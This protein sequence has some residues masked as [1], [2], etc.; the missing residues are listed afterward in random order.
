MGNVRS[1]F[2]LTVLVGA[3]CVL[4]GLVV[5]RPSAGQAGGPSLPV[6]AGVEVPAVHVVGPGETLWKVARRWGPGK[7]PRRVVHEIQVLNGL[8]GGTIHPGQRLRLPPR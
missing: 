3:A 6:P 8:A 7:D 4:I 5:A 1:S 2:R